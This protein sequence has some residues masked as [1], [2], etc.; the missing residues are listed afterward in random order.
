MRAAIIGAYAGADVDA[1]AELSR[2]SARVTH[3]G[4]RARE[5]AMVVALAAG[6][7]ITAGPA[8]SVERI[9]AAAAS[10][11]EGRELAA[12]IEHM[13]PHLARGADPAEYAAS[14]GLRCGVSGYINHTVPVALYCWLRWPSDFRSAVEAAV[15][16]G[17]DTDT[18]AAIVG[19]LVGATAGEAAIPLE[20]LDGLVDWPRS[21]PWMRRLAVRLADRT[22][23]PQRL[24]WPALPL[25]NALFLLVVMLHGFRRLLPPY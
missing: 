19:G 9:L 3:T 2:A 13:A 11:V 1:I 18:V 17:G 10:L 24:F 4:T 5:G 7:A 14:L 20:W 15:M 16:L 6:H 8:V 22:A 21:V 23:G 12:A 25:R